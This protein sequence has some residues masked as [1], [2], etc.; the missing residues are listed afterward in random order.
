MTYGSLVSETGLG[1]PAPHVTVG[2]ETGIPNPLCCTIWDWRTDVIR[3]G[4][5]RSPCI[6]ETAHARQHDHV[7][8]AW[9][10]SDRH[11][12]QRQR[13][14]REPHA[15][16]AMPKLAA[17]LTRA[18][19]RHRQPADFGSISAAGS[20]VGGPVRNASMVRDTG[21][22][23]A[24]AGPHRGWQDRCRSRGLRRGGRADQQAVPIAD[25]RD[26][27]REIAA[28]ADDG[29]GEF[30]PQRVA[31]HDSQV[32]TDIG[33]DGAGRAAADLG[34]D[35][36]GRGQTGDAWFARGGAAVL[37]LGGARLAMGWGG[38]GGRC[39]RLA[40]GVAGQPGLERG[41][42]KQAAGDARED[43]SDGC[44]SAA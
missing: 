4:E 11:V 35:V 17:N 8:R 21:S 37:G 2:S 39:G 16:A 10:W 9:H 12:H 44:R 19:A 43:F 1:R 13:I 3:Y 30:P 23:R 25:V 40:D 27:G 7:P 36:A 26:Q 20:A 32:A 6:G 18:D 31:R 42:A 15:Y 38:Q 22:G 24:G 41:G 34:R 14:E 28:V 5:R 33:E 29:R